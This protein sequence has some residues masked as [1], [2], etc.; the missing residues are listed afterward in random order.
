MEFW[1]GALL[2]LVG[3]GAGFVQRV[4]GFGLSIFAMLF[5]PYL[6]P[7]A[8]AGATVATFLS[9][10]TSGY[11]G[12]KY[13]KSVCFPVLIPMIA[14]AL[15]AIPVAVAL[16][17]YISG[18]AFVIIL[19]VVLILLSIY[20]VFFGGKIRFKANRL[21]GVMAGLTGG[22]LNGLF[23]TGGP[24]VV[25]YLSNVTA[26][27][28]VYFASIQFYFAVTNL[29]AVGVRVANGLVTE[30]VLLCTAVSLVGALLGDLVGKKVFDK[31][32]A[33]ALKRVIYVMM[34]ISG[35]IMLV[36]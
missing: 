10:I 18:D 19:G 25:L 6:M 24:P 22:L 23:S 4:S 36:G 35:V 9:T 11:N 32:N 30:M 31:L 7:S 1:Q 12:I 27:Q 15:V 17:R 20:F 5:L 13:R 3:F 28:T 2:V 33:E 34:L 26:D 21:G 8:Q 16:S 14:A 29:Y